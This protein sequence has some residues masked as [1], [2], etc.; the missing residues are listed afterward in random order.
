MNET[1]ENHFDKTEPQKAPMN[2][3]L[4]FSMLLTLERILTR[5]KVGTN[6]F[7]I[8]AGLEVERKKCRYGLRI[9]APKALRRWGMGRGY[10]Q[11][12]RESG[13]RCEL[14]QRGPGQSPGQKRFWCVLRALERLSLPCM[15]LK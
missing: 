14:P 10:P 12:T 2:K 6:C 8:L 9:E 7:N 13:E 4:F 5:Q 3:I 15:L 1:N 11:L